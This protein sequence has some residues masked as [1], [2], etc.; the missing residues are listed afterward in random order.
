MKQKTALTFELLLLYCPLLIRMFFRYNVIYLFIYLF[1][2][3]FSEP[4]FNHRL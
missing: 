2:L 3:H 1:Q 4:C